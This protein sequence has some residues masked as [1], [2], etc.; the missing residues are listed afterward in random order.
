MAELPHSEYE[1]FRLLKAKLSEL[2][3]YIALGR[4]IDETTFA[5][6][7]DAL[8]ICNQ[9][10]QQEEHRR[11]QLKAEAESLYVTKTK[12]EWIVKS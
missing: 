10:W 1:Y 7:D 11:C 6:Y 12:E 9:T 3:N 8:S 5:A 2:S 4:V